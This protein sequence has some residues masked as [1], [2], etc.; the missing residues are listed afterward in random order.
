[1][2]VM[3]MKLKMLEMLMEEREKGGVKSGLTFVWRWPVVGRCQGW[4]GYAA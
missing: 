2:M 4:I 1:M 3:M